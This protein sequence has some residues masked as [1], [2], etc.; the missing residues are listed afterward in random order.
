MKTKLTLFSMLAILAFVL[1]LPAATTS[2]FAGGDAAATYKA[3]CAGCH[4]AKAEKAFNRS[5]SDDQLLNAALKG[6]K[7]KM[8]SYEKSL[9]ADACKEL[10]AYMKS[11][12]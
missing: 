10:V 6:V 7:P 1:S 4:G 8:P 5:K 12:K 11:L 3:K 2:V 9:G